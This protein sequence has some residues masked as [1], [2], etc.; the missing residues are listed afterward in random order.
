LI[1]FRILWFRQHLVLGGGST[2]GLYLK[3]LRKALFPE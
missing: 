2:H 3:F 1:L